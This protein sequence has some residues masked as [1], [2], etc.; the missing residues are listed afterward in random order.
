MRSVSVV[1]V[2]CLASCVIPAQQP[3]PTY[4]QQPAPGYAAQAPAASCQDTLACYGQC[5][6]MTPSCIATCDQGTTPDSQQNAHAVLQCIGTSGCS[7]QDCVAQQ[8]SA[9]V[10][11]CTNVNVAPAQPAQA[12]QPAQPA[13]P[14]TSG[15][16]QVMT[17]QYSYGQLIVPPPQRILQPTDLVGAWKS[18]DGA[19]ARYADSHGQYAG[20]ISVAI[21]EAWTIDAQ[22]QFQE[23]FAA[24]RAGMNGVSGVNN[25]NVGTVTMHGNNTVTFD[26][27]AQNGSAARQQHYIIVGWFVGPEVILIALQ[28]P[29]YVP[30]TQQDFANAERNAYRIHTYMKK[31]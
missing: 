11:T 19:V 6:P 15:P 2:A 1:V 25:H 30:I 4:A 8:C 22:G 13:Q 5:N 16:D 14:Q 28:G 18:G 9:E 27:P 26:Y 23:E 7:D 31:R 24:A 20:F 29:F 12:A 21:D 17:P 10:M 3:P